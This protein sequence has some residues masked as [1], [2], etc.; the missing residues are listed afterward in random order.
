MGESRGGRAKGTGEQRWA[1]SS[2]LFLLWAQ[3][4]L[5]DPGAFQAKKSGAL[6]C[7][8]PV[9]RLGHG[10]VMGQRTREQERRERVW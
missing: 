4:S 5:W 1:K 10:V 6:G 7:A 8:F 2:M 9:S 3:L